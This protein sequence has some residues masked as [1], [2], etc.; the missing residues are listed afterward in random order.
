MLTTCPAS[1]RKSLDTVDNLAPADVNGE[2]RPIVKLTDRLMSAAG[3]VERLPDLL[4]RFDDSYARLAARLEREPT[5]CG[6]LQP[7]PSPMRLGPGRAPPRARSVAAA[8]YERAGLFQRSKASRPSRP[9]PR[10][11]PCGET[12]STTFIMR[13]ARSRER[14]GAA[15]A[16]VSPAGGRCVVAGRIGRAP[17]IEIGSAAQD[18][19]GGSDA[20]DRAPDWSGF[21]RREVPEGEAWDESAEHALRALTVSHDVPVTEL[22]EMAQEYRRAWDRRG[23]DPK[24]RVVAGLTEL[25]QAWGEHFDLKQSRASQMFDEL[26]PRLQQHV[27]AVG[28]DMDAPLMLR[29]YGLCERKHG[30]GHD[31]PRPSRRSGPRGPLAVSPAPADLVDRNVV[32]V[33][34]VTPEELR[35]AALVLLERWSSTCR[36]RFGGDRSRPSFLARGVGSTSLASPGRPSLRPPSGRPARKPPKPFRQRRRPACQRLQKPPATASRAWANV[37]TG[38]C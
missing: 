9:P 33:P 24:A 28:M 11:L 16:A 26:P 3:S 15:G 7:G 22:S 8:G 14:D 23:M 30:G 34:H 35:A 12:R 29:L 5:C 17:A 37:K 4:G 31:D 10:S 27:R 20:Q 13:V 25:R 38:P 1:I 19:A 18:R 36:M 6:S 32:A 2:F 21:Q